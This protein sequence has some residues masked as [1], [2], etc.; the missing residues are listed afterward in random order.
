MKL[1]NFSWGTPVSTVILASAAAWLAISGTIPAMK[2]RA[3]ANRKNLELRER[4]AT[5]EADIAAYKSEAE[6][7]KSDYQYNRRIYR[8]MTR[9]APEPGD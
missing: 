1:N 9:G 7:L 8:R 3:A 6:A 4:K 2:S 5:V